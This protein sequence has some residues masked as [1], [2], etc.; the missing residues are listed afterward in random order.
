MKTDKHVYLE[1]NV[2][3]IKAPVSW[4]KACLSLLLVP[5]QMSVYITGSYFH[6]IS[7]FKSERLST[8][9]RNRGSRKAL[10]DSIVKQ[11]DDQHNVVL[12]KYIVY[13][14]QNKSLYNAS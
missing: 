10:Y 5:L 2:I 6:I 11:N 13:H 3:H 4:I 1:C 9:Q 12:I 8:C 7:H 14:F